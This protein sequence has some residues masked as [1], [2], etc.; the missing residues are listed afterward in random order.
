MQAHRLAAPHIQ[1]LF[2][3]WEEAGLLHL[4]LTYSGGYAAR[5]I[6]RTQTPS[7]HA[8]G[9]AF[10][11][12]EEWNGQPRTPTATGRRGSIRELVPIAN[13]LGFYWG[14]HYRNRPDGMHFELVV[15]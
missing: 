8:F 5:F 12:N 15:L 1:R 6:S 3:A 9:A 13:S 2:Q 4:V 10:D 7:N 11:I 14:G